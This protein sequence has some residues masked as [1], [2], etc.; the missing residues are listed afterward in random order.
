MS[1]NINSNICFVEKKPGDILFFNETSKDF[2]SISDN[3][4]VF[5]KTNTFVDG[6]G[7]A[8]IM[9]GLMPRFGHNDLVNSDFY[10]VKSFR[11]DHF[12]HALVTLDFFEE[13]VGD[14]YDLRFTDCSGN[15]IRFVFKTTQTNTILDEHNRIIIDISKTNNFLDYAS[16]IKIAYDNYLFSNSITDHKIK[17]FTNSGVL[18]VKQNKPGTFGGVHVN[19][20][21]SINVTD[22]TSIFLKKNFD[23][24]IDYKPFNESIKIIKTVRNNPKIFNKT[25]GINNLD[26]DEEIYFDDGMTK[27]SADFYF[28][29]PDKIKYSYSYNSKEIN[30]LST[31]INPFDTL[32]VIEGKITTEQV[33]VGIKG[34]IVSNGK[35]VRN[36]SNNITFKTN[37]SMDDSFSLNKDSDQLNL[38]GTEAFCD[39]G[40]DDL[41]T[42][43]KDPVTSDYFYDQVTVNNII[44]N[45]LVLSPTPVPVTT[46]SNNE[47]FFL[48]DR[49]RTNSPVDIPFYDISN[50]NLNSMKDTDD[51]K[52]VK[53]LYIISTLGRD[54]D[55]SITNQSNSFAYDWEIE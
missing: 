16:R 12:S 30:S 8:T 31:T 39:E 27:F 50:D 9:P 42:V 15:I 10:D 26:Y 6:V 40:F 19:A 23:F 35:D 2:A 47:L 34:D 45:R 36:R 33:L 29:S 52:H 28:E 1:I 20:G 7:E 38:Y 43:R 54:R 49:E 55:R 14:D 5:T 4:D 44:R 22:Y 32:A 13:I 18:Y 37:L 46:L 48:D 53:N 25:L 41:V 17:L 11:N 51:S 21:N 3:F 24:E